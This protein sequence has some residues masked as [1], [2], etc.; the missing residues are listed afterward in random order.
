MTFFSSLNFKLLGIGIALLVAGYILL[1]QGPVDNPLSRSVAPAILV[2]AYCV[3]LP[4]SIIF[5]GNKKGTKTNDKQE[6]KKGV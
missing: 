3:F 2:A 6:N 4:L 1:G 5:R